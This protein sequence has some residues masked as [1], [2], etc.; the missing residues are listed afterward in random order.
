MT[1]HIIGPRTRSSRAGLLFPVGRVHRHL[2]QGR[3]APRQGRVSSGAPVYFAAV[4]EYLT[5]EI[6]ELAV[7]HC[8]DR[9][10][11]RLIPQHIQLAIHN[12]E[13]LNALLKDATISSGGVVFSPPQ[14]RV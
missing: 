1:P 13:E 7:K 2:R 8:R 10:K 11:R 5:A 12:D 3:Y 14:T 9:K 6:L 4:L